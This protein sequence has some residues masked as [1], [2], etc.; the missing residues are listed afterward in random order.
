MEAA[1]V[2]ATRTR[3][4]M[5]WPHSVIVLAPVADLR[6]S[7]D[8]A[9]ELVDQVHH[10][11]QVRILGAHD[12][13]RYVQAEDHYIGWIR[14]GT[15][16]DA[17]TRHGDQ[18]L[19]GLSLAPIRRERDAASDIVGWLPA[20]TQLP[21]YQPGEDLGA[22]ARI[23]IAHEERTLPGALIGYVSHDDTVRTDDL[24]H[25]PPTADDLLTTAEAFLGVPY[26]WGGTTALGM[27]C[28]GFVQQVYRLNGIRLDRDADQQATEGRQ[29]ESPRA[30]DLLFFSSRGDPFGE[31]RIT[32]VAL[33]TG[34]RTFLHTPQRG[35]AVERGELSGERVPKAIR[36]YLA[37]AR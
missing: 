16:L 35:G 32:H 10:G 29:V 37:E 25:R 1:A 14:P 26:L 20:G 22:W 21:L 33:A 9:A 23:H 5:V 3:V 28:S 11:E 19:V 7:P 6:A 24:P 2:A 12:G 15:V 34:E 13:W 17:T 27:D 31:P 18:R 30:G 4:A 36:R 8:D